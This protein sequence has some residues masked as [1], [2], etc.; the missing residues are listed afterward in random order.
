MFKLYLNKGTRTQLDESNDKYE[1]IKSMNDALKDDAE[2]RFMI[3]QI[4][5]KTPINIDLVNGLFEYAL[6]VESYNE[7]IKQESC[8]GLKRNIVKNVKVKTLA[9]N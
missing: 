1:I 5:N 4:E 7:T 6:Y 3:I 2:A 9:K 8:V